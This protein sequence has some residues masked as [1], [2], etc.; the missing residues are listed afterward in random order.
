LQDRDVVP[1]RWTPLYLKARAT[2]VMKET[3]SKSSAGFKCDT[4]P[5]ERIPVKMKV[6]IA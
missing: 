1:P 6:S 4:I 2:S 3:K 5:I